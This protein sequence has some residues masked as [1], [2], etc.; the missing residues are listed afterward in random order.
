MTSQVHYQFSDTK[1]P[2]HAVNNIL[3]GAQVLLILLTRYY[4]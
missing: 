2:V 1:A 4:T 3:L